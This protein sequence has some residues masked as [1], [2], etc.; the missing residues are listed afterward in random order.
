VHARSSTLRL[1]QFVGESA[2]MLKTYDEIARVAPTN[3]T[4]LIVGETGTGKELAARAIHDLSRHPAGPCVALNCASIS[5]SLIESELFGH[6]RGSFTGAVRRRRGVFEQ[7]AGGTLLL[8]EVTEMPV[9][10]QAK[11]LR[12]LETG[13]FTRVG[14]EQPLSVNVRCLAATNRHPA[15]AVMDGT[16]REDLLYRLKV[17]QLRLPRLA[18]RDGDIPLLAEHFLREVALREGRP[19][20]FTLEAIEALAAHRW[21]GNVR[22]LKNAV[23]SAYVLGGAEVPLACL[24]IEIRSPCVVERPDGD[25]TM[26][27]GV[28][29]AQAERR[30][31]LAT[32]AHLGGS[33]SRAA[34]T[35]GI[36]LKTLYN[37]LHAYK[38]P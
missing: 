10:L 1:G 11:L 19:K 21:P 33:K 8:D 15:D 13:T 28:T 25:I 31:I 38:R 2:A 9:E 23:Y 32:V 17:F 7:A 36:S 14:G 27:V 4:V 35:L 24:P 34:E 18:D 16:L 3:A 20:P 29:V 6:E 12:V 22:E 30:L 26:R 5:P 37:R